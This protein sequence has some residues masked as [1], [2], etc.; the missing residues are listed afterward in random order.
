MTRTISGSFSWAASEF[1]SDAIYETASR[2]NPLKFVD[3][4]GMDLLLNAKTE[5]EAR[6]RYALL[7]KG[8]TASDQKHTQLVVG[9][10]KN[11]FAKGQFGIRVD[12]DYK[13][14][15]ENF[16]AIQ[17]IANDKEQ[18]AVVSIVSPKETFPSN[19]GVKQG[20]T[21]VIQSFKTVFGVDNYVSKADAV[22]GQ[23]LFPLS[24]SPVAN[25]I[26]ST[27][28]NTEV[29][30][31]NDMSDVE[32]VA[33]SFHELRAHVFLSNVGRDIPRGSHGSAGVDQ[34]AKDAETEAR[35]NFIQNTMR[36]PR[37]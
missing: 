35:R 17:K 15:S 32:I 26:Y 28:K 4:E 2:N 16:Q 30:V 1:C 8:L 27:S 19:V 9:D 33:T 21:V 31:A 3:P 22:L 7:Q 5:E 29:Y 25:T 37:R 34:A 18:T 6:K 12:V 10:G 13:S 36:P 20:T 11:G 14:K 23:T 24:G